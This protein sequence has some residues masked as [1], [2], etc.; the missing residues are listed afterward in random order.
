MGKYHPGAG[1]GNHRILFCLCHLF[2]GLQC[3]NCPIQVK[4]TLPFTLPRLLFCV[5]P[6]YLPHPLF[7]NGCEFSATDTLCY[8]TGAFCFQLGIIFPLTEQLSGQQ[9]I[10]IHSAETASSSTSLH[11]FELYLI[12]DIHSTSTSHGV[13]QGFVTEP[14]LFSI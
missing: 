13:P 9:P 7:I 6:S 5:I 14:R 1:C 11:W 10:R 12:R 2:R 3:L 4:P 8:N